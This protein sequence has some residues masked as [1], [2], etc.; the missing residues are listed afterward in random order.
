MKR[1]LFWQ[2]ILCGFILGGQ[3]A[4]A[5]DTTALAD[6]CVNLNGDVTTACNG[7]GSGGASGSGTINLV[8]FDPALEPNLN[9]LGS[10]TI[11]LGTGNGQSALFYGDY[12]LDYATYGSFDDSATTH[13]V[14]PAFDSY[15]VNDPNAT[16]SS[17]PYGV[18][19]FDQFYNNTLD[20]TNH[21]GTASG[22]PT[23][24]CD[25]A[26]ALGLGDLNVL[27]G[28]SGTVTFTVG[29]IAPAAGFYIQQTNA[30]DGD[31]IYL[32]ATANIQ[33]P[34]GSTPEPSTFALGLGSLGLAL[35]VARR[36]RVN[37]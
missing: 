13:G 7:A 9:G 24:C 1:L 34:G 37:G 23:Q 28:G 32:S 30:T 14:F 19:L 10:I 31:S 25:V 3:V 22:P 4:Q 26:F 36:R 20:D 21:V 18:T 29:T 8:S 27:P 15:S 6:W 33:N 11:T 5:A 17:L 12:D 35:F 16:D 2:F